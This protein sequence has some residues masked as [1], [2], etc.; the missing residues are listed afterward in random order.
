MPEERHLTANPFI[1]I[2]RL[3]VLDGGSEPAASFCWFGGRMNHDSAQV[4][5]RLLPTATDAASVFEH[6]GD[7]FIAP[8]SY[9]EVRGA[10]GGYDRMT[11]PTAGPPIPSTESIPDLG[12]EN[13]L[14]RGY[15]S[16][17]RGVIKLR[18]GRFF[19]ELNAPTVDDAESLAR[20]LVDMLHT[21]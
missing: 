8:R 10:D 3:F 15:G 5:V 4:M 19:A 14:W 6:E 21:E 12:D 17:S 16:N 18:L 1:A 13:R 20:R 9:V 7:Q 11:L 2:E